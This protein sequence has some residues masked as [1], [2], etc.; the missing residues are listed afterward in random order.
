MKKKLLSVAL[1]V[2]FLNAG[3]AIGQPHPAPGPL[4]GVQAQAL[5]NDMGEQMMFLDVRNPEEF[6]QGHMPGAL[7]IPLSEL[8][9]RL[10]EIPGDK[11]IFISCLAGGRSAQAFELLTK[12]HPELID[13]GIWFL[14]A[15][16][17]Y[18][19]DGS[20]VFHDP[21]Q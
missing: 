10:D 9:K 2:V 12:K 7:N 16:P 20:F 11:P 19:P 17:E 13:T 21:Q 14:K 15:K 6:A 8:E 4:D 3:A 5:I 18:K 1:L